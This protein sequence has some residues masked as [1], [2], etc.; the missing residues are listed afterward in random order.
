MRRGLAA[1]A[2]L[3][4]AGGAAALGTAPTAAAHG[5]R[6][7]GHVEGRVAAAVSGDNCAFA[8]T[9]PPIDVPTGFPMPDD[10]Q[11][12]CT[13]PTPTP[14]RPPK[15]RPPRIPARTAPGSPADG[16]PDA[17]GPAAGAAQPSTGAT[18]LAHTPAA[19]ARTLTGA[20]AQLRSGVPEAA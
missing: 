17:T 11:F 2:L 13:K 5:S 20:A 15:P 7:E 16:A 12:P 10:W 4:L 19:H 1:A 14:P 6:V 8:G 18:P 3:L 9:S